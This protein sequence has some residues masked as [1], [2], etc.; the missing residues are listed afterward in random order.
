MDEARASVAD[1]SRPFAMIAGVCGHTAQART[2][3]EIAAALGYDAGLLSLGDLAN[4]ERKTSCSSIA[5]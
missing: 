3:A 2:E 5:A 1:T 4:R